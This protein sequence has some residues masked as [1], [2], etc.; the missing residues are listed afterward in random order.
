MAPDPYKRRKTRHPGI[1]YRLRKDGSR[2]YF[3]YAQGTQHPVDGGERE[4]LEFQAKLRGKIARGER[5]TSAKIT[6]GPL[7][8]EWYSS[9]Q[10]VLRPWTLKD[11]RASLDRILLPRY[12]GVKVTQI[13]ADDVAALIRDLEA[14]GLAGSTISNYL[15][16]LS[17]TLDLAVRRGVVS[18]N[19][20]TLLT[21]DERPRS[22]EPKEFHI[23]SDGEIEE[24]IGCAELLA[25]RPEGRYDY[26]PIVRTG[27]S[28]G[29]RMGELLGL[30]WED[31]DKNDPCI[32]VRRQWT[33]L[34]AYGPPK[35][36]AARRRVPLPDD[37]AT[38]L[39]ALKLR[40]SY[41]QDSEP[42]FASRAG[43]P[44]SHRNVARRGF[45]P[46]RSLAGIEGVSFHDLRHAFASRMIAK[47]VSSTVLARVMG[48]ESAAITE[49]KYIHLFDKVKTDELVRAAMRLS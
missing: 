41:S 45:E 34:G 1:T 21:K 44:L 36:E 9:K 32:Y 43:T 39:V 8:E 10:R 37:L 47:G 13:T 35:T 5:V 2:K 27:I 28:T 4:A 14:R 11:Y 3:V 12:L 38:Y 19:V 16:P 40:S 6:F 24:L 33:R 15:L 7:A 46:A 25:R 31:F 30:W 29:L 49:R 23:W 42:I 48:H 17:G 18:V 20:L 22:G 26:S